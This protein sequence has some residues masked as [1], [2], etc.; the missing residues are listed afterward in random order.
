MINLICAYLSHS[1][2]HSD[3]LSNLLVSTF[4]EAK[5]TASL[6][7]NDDLLLESLNSKLKSFYYK[8]AWL[9]MMSQQKFGIPKRRP[10]FKTWDLKG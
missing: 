3:S 6:Y 9:Y 7:Y 5:A 1:S 4:T 10:P 8:I 2:L